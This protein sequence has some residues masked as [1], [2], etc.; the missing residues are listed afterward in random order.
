MT[1]ST[2]PSF[3][4]LEKGQTVAEREVAIT[5]DTLV[6]YAGASGDF[7]PIHYN[8]IIAEEVGL[9]GV[10]AH[11][12]LTMGIGA[13]VVEEWA[14]AGNVS[15]YQVRFTRPIPVPNPGAASVAVV[16]RIGALDEER[17]TARVDLTVE[18][19]GAKVLG[20]AQAIVDCE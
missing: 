5:R 1:E 2:S 11:G 8:D 18:F 6:R 17:R 4:G 3:D 15:D 14:G 9:P 19:E 20:K 12:M 7:N 16:A 10:I 13:S